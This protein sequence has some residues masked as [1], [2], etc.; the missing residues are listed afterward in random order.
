M[1]HY[2]LTKGWTLD[3][4][5]VDVLLCGPGGL[6]IALSAFDVTRLSH[7]EGLSPALIGSLRQLSWAYPLGEGE[8][9]LHYIATWD[10]EAP[11]AEATH[12]LHVGTL[13]LWQ[14]PE[15]VGDRLQA[16]FA[17]VEERRR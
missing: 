9:E 13:V 1:P 12:R 17:Q 6:E 8:S 7:V 14:L 2:D 16:W 3:D 10:T 11:D 4:D 15:T 5:G